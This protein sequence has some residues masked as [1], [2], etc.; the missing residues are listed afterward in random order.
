MKGSS[1]FWAHGPCSN[2][3]TYAWGLSEARDAHM[4]VWPSL[5][6][7]QANKNN[8]ERKSPSQCCLDT[9]SLHRDLTKR[10]VVDVKAF[11]RLSKRLNCL[12]GYQE[13]LKNTVR[14]LWQLLFLLLNQQICHQTLLSIV[15]YQESILTRKHYWRWAKL[16]FNGGAY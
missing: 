11:L 1:C 3:H 13:R 14:V 2:T 4:I 7:P 12:F 8:K 15:L 9:N 6:L 5:V 10:R 16:W